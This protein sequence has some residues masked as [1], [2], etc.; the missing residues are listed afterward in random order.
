[1]LKKSVVVL[2]SLFLV[3]PLWAQDASPTEV[4]FYCPAFTTA[5]DTE[6]SSYY[7]GEGAAF[8]RSGNYDAA[9][10]A[11]GCVIQQIDPDYRDAYLNRAAA[12]TARRE[13]DQAL[14]DFTD[15]IRVDGSYAPAYNNRGVVYTALLD[16]DRA[17][18]DFDRALDL[19]ADYA[20]AYINRGILK[21]ITGDYAAAEADFQQAVDVA[22]LA[23]VV[24]NLRDPERAADAPVPPYDIAA[25]RAYALI[26]TIH[27]A[28]ALSAYN[29]YLLLTGGRADERVRSAAGALESRF[30]FELRFDDGS[31]MLVANF[32]AQ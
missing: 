18:S 7:M 30:Q 22:D 24:A 28:R 9:I 10:N 2:L 17:L 5:S 20:Y 19:D 15:A 21:A 31:W 13:Y 14:E 12:Y 32:V 1:M 26:G 8:L 6:R 3:L 4:P 23:A 29:D 11:Y 27:S 25:V 16:Y